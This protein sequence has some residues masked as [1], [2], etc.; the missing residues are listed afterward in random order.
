MTDPTSTQRR[1]VRA[2]LGLYAVPVAL[3]LAGYL[4]SKYYFAGLE[5]RRLWSGF[6]I[7]QPSM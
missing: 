3:L 2:R 7:R 1:G 4:A 6:P 5:N